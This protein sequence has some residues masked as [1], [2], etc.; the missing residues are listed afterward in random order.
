[1]KRLESI[2]AAHPRVGTLL[3]FEATN[4]RGQL[5]SI[6]FFPCEGTDDVD[7]LITDGDTPDAGVP[8]LHLNGKISIYGLKQAV[9]ALFAGRED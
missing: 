4:V 2:A 9:I 1:M 6:G 7:W 3:S 5:A 8:V